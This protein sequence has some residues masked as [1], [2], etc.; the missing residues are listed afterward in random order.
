MKNNIKDVAR[1][2][3]VSIATVSHVINNT[4]FVS[5]EKRRKILDAIEGLNYQPNFSAR[6]LRTRKVSHVSIYICENYASKNPGMLNKTLEYLID[7]I[8]GR[9]W[10]T[11][12]HYVS[13]R[14]ILTVMES[15]PDC[16]FSLLVTLSSGSYSHVDLTAKKLYVLNMDKSRMALL[17]QEDREE[18]RFHYAGHYYFTFIAD[19][20]SDN[21]DK[22][23]CFFMT[24]EDLTILRELYADNI[25]YKSIFT[26]ITAI[27]S[28]MSEAQVVLQ[29]L[30]SNNTY[31]HIYLT[32]YK[33][34][35]G[36]VR[37]LLTKPEL[38]HTRTSITF[39]GYDCNLENFNLFIKNKPF[40]L[41]KTIMDEIIARAKETF[42]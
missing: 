18:E 8:E 32:D 3:G 39:L 27:N 23:Y 33:F 36:A 4:H 42:T 25:N 10:Q 1:H 9:A 7:T 41:S 12:V 34:A 16:I 37:L 40:F 26:R 2:A 17:R 13:P 5:E 20:I 28:E 29:D 21:S 30:L 14:T 22:N 38:I 19:Y 6:N 35:L 15:Q 11:L 31:E 24:W